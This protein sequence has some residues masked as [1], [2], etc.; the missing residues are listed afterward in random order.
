MET[1]VR[2]INK[3]TGVP[4]DVQ[5]SESGDAFIQY[6]SAKY[7]E[8]S[9]DGYAFSVKVATA[10]VPIIAA[11][12]TTVGLGLFNSAADGGKSMII[13]ALFAICTVTTAAV[14]QASL[15]YALGQTRVAALTGDLTIRKANGMGP[16]TD[17][18]CL[19]S[20]GGAILAADPGVAI[21]YMVIGSPVYH[22]VASEIGALLYADVGG[23]LIIP[24]G[25]QFGLTVIASA[26]GAARF[27][28]GASWHEKQIKL[29]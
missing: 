4:M 25:R 11:P 3:V 7:E 22:M 9:R 16:T 10:T 18:V 27:Q 15:L 12:T 17:S 28:C 23:R 20:A 13:D 19:A 29:H 5:G 6:G 21:S 26:A 8:I 14:G 1:K 2:M 24:P